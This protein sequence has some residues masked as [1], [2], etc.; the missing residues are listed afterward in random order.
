MVTGP[1]LPP[2]VVS[3]TPPFVTV[4]VGSAPPS[5]P[6]PPLPTG[7]EGPESAE[8]QASAT[9]T[10]R[11]VK[12]RVLLRLAMRFEVIMKRPVK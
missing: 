9:E 2:V 5:E 8:L 6:L 12:A 11:Q 7:L 10:A 1:R 3:T 4:A